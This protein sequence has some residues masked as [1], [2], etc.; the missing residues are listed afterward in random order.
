MSIPGWW[1]SWTTE[2]I[3]V[4]VFWWPPG[5]SWLPA[6]VW[7][8]ME[9]QTSRW[10]NL[11]PSWRHHDVTSSL[12]QVRLGEHN[13]GKQGETLIP[14]KNLTV[15][16]SYLH[17]DYDGVKAIN[18][19]ALL[20]V[21]EEV[22]LKVYTPVCLP[23]EDDSQDYIGKKAWIYGKYLNWLSIPWLL[24]GC[25]FWRIFSKELTRKWCRLGQH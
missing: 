21:K 2:D 3:S 18:D 24:F 22:D 19:I 20:E 7:W 12:L 5:T 13:L 17:E 11:P 14:E 16:R 1:P 10:A 25:E 4:L 8:Q 6:T 23:S 9:T 15:V